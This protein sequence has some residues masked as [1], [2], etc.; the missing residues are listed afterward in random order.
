MA[1]QPT[2][3]QAVATEPVKVVPVPPPQEPQVPKD[4]PMADPRLIEYIERLTE[5]LD[6]SIKINEDLNATNQTLALALGER[7][8]ALEEKSGAVV[9]YG[10][11]ETHEYGT[12]TLQ[13]P[14]E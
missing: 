11:V 12:I 6:N 7:V 1:V 10:P 13:Q 4:V 2:K 5:A 14:K 8:K 3:G 9:H